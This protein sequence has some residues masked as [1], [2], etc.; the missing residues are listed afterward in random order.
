MKRTLKTQ[1]KE[2]KP[3]SHSIKKHIA[4]SLAVLMLSLIFVPIGSVNAESLTNEGISGFTEF[5]TIY[6]DLNNDLRVNALDYALMK[7]LLL[8]NTGK[9]IKTADVNGDNELNVLDLSLMKQFLLGSILRFPVGNTFVDTENGS[10]I[11]VEQNKS[12]EITLEENGSTGYQWFYSISDISALNLISEENLIYTSPELDGAPIQK[13]WTFEALEPGTYTLTFEY[14]RPWQQGIAPIEIVECT[15]IVSSSDENVINVTTNEPFS[16]S[17]QEGGIVGFTSTCKISDESVL[18][19][20]EELDDFRP[21]I[22][23]WLYSRIYTFI[24]TEPGQYK[25]VFTQRPFETK[26]VYTVNVK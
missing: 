7:S 18:L 14:K 8:D 11:Y 15:I 24:A 17:M 20:S 16:I 10:I 12:F 4:I 19:V 26:I 1:T 22:A 21:E 9:Y 23:D 2:L 13:I 3:I 5:T 25:I 6:G